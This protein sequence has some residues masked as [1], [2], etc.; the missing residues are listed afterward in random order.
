[1]NNTIDSQLKLLDAEETGSGK[2]STLLVTHNI[3]YENSHQVIDAVK[4]SLAG[5]AETVV[6][7]V[8]EVSMID[9]SGLRA[10]LLSR[11]MCDDAGA[12]FKLLSISEAVGRVIRMSGF[13]CAFGLAPI[14][15][16]PAGAEHPDMV[17]PAEAKWKVYERQSTSD[18]YVIA[19]LRRVVLDAAIEAGA[20]NDE[21]CDIQIAVGEA[22][23]NAYRHGSPVKGVSKIKMRCM[24]CAC[25]VVVEIEDEGSPFDPDSVAEPDPALLRD[26]GMGIYLMRQAMDV[27]DFASGCPGNRVRM[28]KWIKND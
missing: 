13:A 10:L 7:D 22:L 6:L 12:S 16:R 19:V 21:I 14:E 8:S 4:K 15:A 17:K 23:T 2:H 24:T 18:P 25:A 9:S 27:V 11:R 26:H 28:I 20:T 3:D 1:M 5:G